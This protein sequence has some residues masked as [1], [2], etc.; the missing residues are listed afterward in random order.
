MKLRVNL[1]V[2]VKADIAQIII[3]SMFASAWLSAQPSELAPCFPY[4][5]IVDEQLVHVPHF[6]VSP[7]FDRS[8]PDLK[9]EAESAGRA[10]ELTAGSDH[11]GAATWRRIMHATR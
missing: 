3:A 4:A 1:S 9:T 11:E 2:L 7:P 5:S 10:D 8:A 6:N